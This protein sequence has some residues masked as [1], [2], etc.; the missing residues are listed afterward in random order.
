[1]QEGTPPYAMA[2]ASTGRGGD[3]GS[4]DT[5]GAAVAA[6]AAA[7]AEAA[8]AAG[9]G[10]ESLQ[11]GP[12][13]AFGAGSRGVSLKRGE[14]FQRQP[15]RRSKTTTVY[16]IDEPL[17]L[18]PTSRRV[19]EHIW[20]SFGGHLHMPRN[21]SS[22]GKGGGKGGMGAAHL[23]RSLRRFVYLP[24]LPAARNWRFMKQHFVADLCAGLTCAV[25]LIPQGKPVG[26]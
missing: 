8:A 7:A 4:A 13:G 16:G 6:G 20:Q 22:F 11:E 25:M 3:S 18:Q 24:G 23:G 12:A 15:M 5:P 17:T 10:Q 19:P 2:P 9:L 21:L 14:S 26:R 1:M